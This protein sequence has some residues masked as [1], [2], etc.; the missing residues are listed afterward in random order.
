MIN[1]GFMAIC[2]SYIYTQDP[3]QAL[4]KKK[5][6]GLVGKSGGDDT[7][8]KSGD[9]RVATGSWITGRPAAALIG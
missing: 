8:A 9:S 7:F 4:F 3:D 2:Y 5:I 1:K 6:V